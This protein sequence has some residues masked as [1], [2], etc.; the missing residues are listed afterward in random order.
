MPQQKSRQ[1]H[2]AHPYHYHY[3]SPLVLKLAECVLVGLR[4]AHLLSAL[5]FILGFFA[6]S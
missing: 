3:L 5:F 4:L 2:C 1:A 6:V